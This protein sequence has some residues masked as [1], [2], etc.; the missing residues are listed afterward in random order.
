MYYTLWNLVAIFLDPA[1]KAKVKPVMTLSGIREHIEDKYIPAE[2]V[3][4]VNHS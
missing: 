3:C 1:T 4:E 2:M